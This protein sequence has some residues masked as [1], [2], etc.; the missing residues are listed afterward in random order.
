M[1]EGWTYNEKGEL[2]RPNGKMCSRGIDNQSGY[3]QRVDVNKKLYHQHRIICLLRDGGW[4]EVTDHINRDRADNRP[5]NLRSVT[6][7]L[8]NMNLVGRK[9]NTSGTQ[10]VFFHTQSGKWRTKLQVMGKTITRHSS[11]KEEAIN[12]RLALEVLYNVRG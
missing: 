8:N 2:F 9:D 11:T 6:K 3:R 12:K 1:F 5:A 7:S 4:P 10:G